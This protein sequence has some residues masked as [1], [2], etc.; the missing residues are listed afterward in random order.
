M[1]LETYSC[2]A[3]Q[4]M[5]KDSKHGILL[6]VFPLAFDNMLLVFQNDH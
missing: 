4:S 5:N 2:N 3:S 1:A 6:I